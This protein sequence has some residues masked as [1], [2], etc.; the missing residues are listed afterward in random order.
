MFLFLLLLG[1]LTLRAAIREPLERGRFSA[2][3]GI[4]GV[5]LVPFIHLSV[6][7]WRGL[8]PKPII[9]KPS[10]PSLPPEMLRTMFI[11]FSVFL[12]LYVG[13]VTLRYGIQLARDIREAPMSRKSRV[14]GASRQALGATVA[15]LLTAARLLAQTTGSL[16]GQVRTQNGMTLTGVSV[17][18]DSTEFTAT[19]DSTG[20]YGPEQHSGRHRR[21]HRP[22]SGVQIRCE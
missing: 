1:Y 4:M 7:L 22:G 14:R 9:I 17:R 12:L 8:H 18:I 6:Y 21:P 20:H 3:L 13:F 15:L 11:G 10:A 19:A 5:V 2:V 16:E